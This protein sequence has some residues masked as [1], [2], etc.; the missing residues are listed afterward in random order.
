MFTVSFTVIC[1]SVFLCVA[2]GEINSHFLKAI[3]FVLVARYMN[4]LLSTIY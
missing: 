2:F 1:R 4:T 3:G